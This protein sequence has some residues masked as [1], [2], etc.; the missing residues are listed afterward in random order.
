MFIVDAEKYKNTC[1]LN[2][3][4]KIKGNLEEKFAYLNVIGNLR[5]TNRDK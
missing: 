4:L 3:L 1:E 2:N 5:Q